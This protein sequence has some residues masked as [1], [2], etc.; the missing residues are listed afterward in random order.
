MRNRNKKK[1][2]TN[3]ALN[4]KNCKFYLR[5][6]EQSLHRKLYVFLREL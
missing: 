4:E 2:R 1:R 3:W 6:Y 5:K